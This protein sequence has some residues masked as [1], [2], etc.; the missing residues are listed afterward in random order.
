MLSPS[1]KR[2]GSPGWKKYLRKRKALLLG[3]ANLVEIDLLRGGTRLPMLD[4][5]PPSPY[6]VLVARDDWAPLCKVW[7]AYFDKPLPTLRVPLS[8]PDPDIAVSLQPLVD[9]VYERS[10]YS[11]DIDYS[12]PLTP[13]LTAEQTAWLRNRVHAAPSSSRKRSR[14]RG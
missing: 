3:K 10:R 7:P 1:N 9:G 13:P 6:Y 8:K 12:R 4:P 14:K 11:Q 2:K 5:W